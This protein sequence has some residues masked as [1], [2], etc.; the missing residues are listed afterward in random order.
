[1]VLGRNRKLIDSYIKGD[2]MG[3]LGGVEWAIIIFVVILLFGAKRIP[4]LARGIGDGIRE[5][6]NARLGSGDEDKM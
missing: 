2:K 5:F 4:K 3:I 1:M 6:N